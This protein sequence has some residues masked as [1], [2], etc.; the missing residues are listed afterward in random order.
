MT[1][2]RLV[3]YTCFLR[4]RIASKM[5]RAAFSGDATQNS[6]SPFAIAGLTNHDCTSVT[7]M[8]SFSLLNL[9]RNPCI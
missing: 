3:T 6:P 9:C 1:R 2:Q 5:C 4:L 7:T 8:G